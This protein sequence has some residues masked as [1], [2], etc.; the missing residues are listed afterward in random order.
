MRNAK[1]LII[2]ALLFIFNIALLVSAEYLEK[3]ES[4]NM[5]LRNTKTFEET[6]KDQLEYFGVKT[7]IDKEKGMIKIVDKETIANLKEKSSHGEI[8]SRFYQ[9]QEYAGYYYQ[10]MKEGTSDVL[11]ITLLEENSEYA[12]DKVSIMY[13]KDLSEYPKG[14]YKDNLE[15]FQNVISPE[16]LSI[17]KYNF[18]KIINTYY[19]KND[20]GV[21]TTSAYY[22]SEEKELI[23]TYNSY[24]SAVIKNKGE[25]DHKEV[26]MTEWRDV[27]FLT[28]L[29]EAGLL[30][31]ISFITA[32][33][34]IAGREIRNEVIVKGK[35][36]K[37]LK[38][39]KSIRLKNRK[40]IKSRKEKELVKENKTEIENV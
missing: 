34:S 25:L 22:K 4:E 36:E 29:I 26:E 16:M 31:G 27:V 23:K 15:K 7:E 9:N 38:S 1:R 5:E 12:I 30:L 24:D 18:D 2:Y 17:D 21:V 20:E 40:I 33:M 32:L 35:I 11:L 14:T 6:F 28:M 19:L 37:A 13:E 10:M 8:E 3:K 39:K